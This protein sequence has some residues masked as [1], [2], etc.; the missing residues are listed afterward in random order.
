MTPHWKLS[1]RLAR[2][3]QP[4][5]AAS[6]DLRRPDQGLCD[7]TF[8]GRTL[9]LISLLAIDLPDVAA[10][11]ESLSDV[12]VRGQDVVAVYEP[13]PRRPTRVEVYWR[14]LP[15]AADA[16]LAQCAALELQVSVQTQLLDSHPEVSCSTAVKAASAAR[17]QAS[18]AWQKAAQP[19]ATFLPLA[20]RGCTLWSWLG[21]D[22][23]YAEM[24]F[25]ADFRVDQLAHE[26]Q[27]RWRLEHRLFPEFLEKGV[28]LRSRIRGLFCPAANAEAAAS[29]AFEQFAAAPLPLTT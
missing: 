2:L 1:G 22:A 11:P 25:P 3:S 13:T 14:W 18:G 9:P 23:A 15:I 24:V 17:L 19:V 27:D 21:D 16:G 26:S 29:A 8:R 6:V 7:V 5:L 20:D 10:E 4:D 28:I 12:W